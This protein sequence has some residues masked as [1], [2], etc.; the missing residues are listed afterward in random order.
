[1]RFGRLTV[2]KVSEHKNAKR[3]WKCICDCGN[4]AETNTYSLTH[5]VCRSCGCL[6]VEKAVVA[7]TVHGQ[8]YTKLYKIWESMKRR[9]D[10]PK[11][12]RY[13]RY[14]GRGITYCD[15]WKAFIPFFEWAKESGYH[16]ELSLDRIN[17]DG[18][19]EP[20]NC[21]WITMEEQA[22]NTSQNKHVIYNG[23]QMTVAEFAKHIG[24]S[25]SRVYQ[26]LYKLNWTPEQCASAGGARER[27]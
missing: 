27:A 3:M 17:C 8:R 6:Q 23:N 1:M 26:E 12:Q 10:S 24:R 21:R 4:T 5:G 14:G 9:C 18:N 7:G 11:A 20:K 25:Y 13:S 19:Y 2:L 22:N 15:E 16:E